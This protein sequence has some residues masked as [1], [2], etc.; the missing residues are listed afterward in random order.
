MSA[1][2]DDP[3]EAARD[4]LDR[5]AWQEAYDVLAE[6]DR[7][8]GLEPGGLELLFQ[9]AWWLGRP[10]ETLD[11][12]ER[13]FKALV[14]AG[15]EERAAAM[16]FRLAE[17]HLARMAG[18]L[19]G[20]WVAKAERL[21]AQH[22]DAVEWGYLAWVKGFMAIEFEGHFDEGIRS[23]DQALEIAERHGDRSLFGKVLHDKGRAVAWS[24]RAEEG[25]AMMDEAMASAVGGEMEA[26]EAGYVYCSMIAVCSHLGDYRRASEWTDA[27]QLW[28]ERESLPAFSG[29]CRVHRAEL[30]RHHGDLQAAEAEA[31]KA[32]EELPRFNFLF[33]MGS[34]WYE[35][36]EV[37]RR[38]GDFQ[39]AEEAFVKT[40]E[41]GLYPEAGL[42]LSR[43]G[44]GR[45][46][47]A[48]EGV[49]Q[50][51]RDGH[52]DPLSRARYLAA[53]AQIALA[54][55]DA[56]G[57][58]G[59]ITELESLIEPFPSTSLRA[60]AQAARGAIL[61][62]QGEPEQALGPL[63]DALRRRQEEDAPYEASEIRLLLA[64]AHRALGEVEAAAME[65]RSARST[66]A[67]IG[68]KAAEATA[69]RSLS[70]L[71]AAA[72]TPERV[73]RAFV[74]TDIVGST[75]L[76]GLLGD[77]AWEDLLAWHDQTLR[78]L[79]ARHGGEEA[80]H[81]G[82]GFFA[83]FPDARSAAACAVDIQRA[84]A[85]HRREHGFSPPVRIGIHAAEATRRGS[86]F[87]GAEV[88]KASRIADSAQ[89]GEILLSDEAYAQAGAELAVLE[90]REAAL[91]GI[92]APVRLVSISWRD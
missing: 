46:E 51:L 79:F 65:L 59:A 29:I 14:E 90:E 56:A 81:T 19:V 21:L 6:A 80:H 49:R 54:L 70:G 67:R 85:S 42:S 47:A 69:E 58:A 73:A 1:R 78:A 27:T 63:R 18:P 7:A 8:G 62:A 13:A 38:L 11:V 57:A 5:H 34:A 68:A 48:A 33:G 24:G 72:G 55:G 74:F 20:G 86:D 60:T 52:R 16:A 10:E 39:G 25:L 37:R 35:I 87:S 12:G 50:A 66:F 32:F 9:A 23:F 3:L 26:F 84:L 31:R 61:V 28:C 36:G 77:E 53:Q 92:P 76:A 82:D 44:Q 88:H 40:H 41:A 91:K 30:L 15:Q 71:L 75:D 45:L 89:G 4:A 64:E 43:L 83:T 2:L 17:Q 22:P